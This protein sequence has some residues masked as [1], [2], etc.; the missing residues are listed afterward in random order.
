MSEASPLPVTVTQPPL[1]SDPT[2]WM[3]P[4]YAALAAQHGFGK[5][6]GAWVF[7]NMRM[8]VSIVFDNLEA[9]TWLTIDVLQG[10]G[11]CAG[12]RRE[13]VD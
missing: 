6:S 9:G 12:H 4:Y 2:V 5:V 8:P 3:R 13:R 7:R 1:W 11:H 10:P